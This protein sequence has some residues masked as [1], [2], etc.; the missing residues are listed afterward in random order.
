M[1]SAVALADLAIRILSP[2][3]ADPV[4]SI[5]IPSVPPPLVATPSA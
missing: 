1:I 4:N 2:A 5:S 3:A